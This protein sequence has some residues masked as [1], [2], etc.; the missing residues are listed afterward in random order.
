M[1]MF[2]EFREEQG[3]FSSEINGVRNLNIDETLKNAK[4]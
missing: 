4:P 3:K 1:E 2:M